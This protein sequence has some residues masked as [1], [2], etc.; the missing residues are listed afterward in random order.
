MCRTTYSAGAE[1]V[2]GSQILPSGTVRDTLYPKA[3]EIMKGSAEEIMKGSVSALKKKIK[4]L[5][6]IAVEEH[7]KL[8][9]LLW[10][11]TAKVLKLKKIQPPIHMNRE[12][13]DLFLRSLTSEFAS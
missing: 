7:D 2:A 8:L 9:S 5:G 12:L 10:T 4:K 13:V 11:M 1:C 6:L 3:E